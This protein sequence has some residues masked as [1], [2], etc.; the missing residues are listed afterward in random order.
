MIEIRLAQKGETAPQ[1]EIWKLCF[2]DSSEY[3]NL[4]YD[5]RYKEEDTLLLLQGG[6]IVSMLTMRPVTLV[7]SLG[8]GVPSVMLYAIATHPDFQ[9][10]GLITQLMEFCHQYLKEHN[11]AY[12]ILVPAGQQLAD[13]YRQWGYRYAFSIREAKL[14]AASLVNLP[15]RQLAHCLISAICPRE[16][17]RRRNQLL[18]GKNYISYPEAEIAYQKKLSQLLDADI[19]AL[20]IV[21]PNE[22]IQGCAAVERISEDQVLIREILLPEKHISW[23]IRL[24]T[25]QLP[26]KGYIVRTPMEVG[27]YL[28]GTK[29]PLGMLKAIKEDEAV[30]EPDS[31]GYLGLAFD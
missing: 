3:I 15:G 4:F 13:F 14:N 23:V 20:D 30:I 27:S 10:Q 28:G 25:E 9:R 18:T 24:L 5:Y 7:N 17:N 6:I 8:S 29:K 19:Y 2:G 26:A 16:Y 21:L 11:F 31:P 1:K 22:K 12:S